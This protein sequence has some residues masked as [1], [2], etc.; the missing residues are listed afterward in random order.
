MEI[1]RGRLKTSPNNKQCGRLSSAVYFRKKVANSF[2]LPL[3]EELRILDHLKMM[4][5]APKYSELYVTMR[6]IRNEKNLNSF[7]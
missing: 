2:S 6:R 4:R 1:L 5:V 3:Q 7:T